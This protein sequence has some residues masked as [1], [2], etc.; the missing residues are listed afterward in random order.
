MD[1]EKFVNTLNKSKVKVSFTKDKSK[2]IGVAYNICAY[3]TYMDS[4]D[5]SVN[6]EPS[7]IAFVTT[8]LDKNIKFDS[9]NI[10]SN[11]E[12]DPVVYKEI[13]NFALMKDSQKIIKLKDCVE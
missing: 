6:A 7:S 10:Y 12:V 8:S 11:N 4:I 3:F 13:L 1:Y 9:W 2:I 5:R